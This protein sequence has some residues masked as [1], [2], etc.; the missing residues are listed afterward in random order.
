MLGSRLVFGG[1]ILFVGGALGIFR[2]PRDEIGAW[3]VFAVVGAALT[4]LGVRI[5][6]RGTKDD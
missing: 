6:R 3:V 4:L 5:M 1:L 2:V